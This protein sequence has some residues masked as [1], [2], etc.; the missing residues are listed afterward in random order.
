MA[1]VYRHRVRFGEVDA[2]GIL[3]YPRLFEI[4]HEAYEDLFPARFGRPFARF[5]DDWEFITPVVGTQA[6]FVEPMRLGDE[7]D[8]RIDVT[9]IGDRSYTLR[10]RFESAGDPA[11]VRAELHVTHCFI[12]RASGASCGIPDTFRAVLERDL[13][14]DPVA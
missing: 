1:Y 4:A 10:F 6:R 2:A 12:L 8:V 13:A 3:Y 7:L 11:R 5:I 9:R 14:S